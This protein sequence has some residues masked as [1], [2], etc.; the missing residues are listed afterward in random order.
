MWGPCLCQC[1]LSDCLHQSVALTQAGPYRRQTNNSV[2]SHVCV[3]TGYLLEVRGQFNKLQ[4]EIE[5]NRTEIMTYKQHLFFQHN[6]HTNLNT[7]PTVSHGG[8]PPLCS[9]GVFDALVVFDTCPPIRE[10]LHPIMDCL[11]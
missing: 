9:D 3:I 11:T 2:T 7:C 4:I 10:L 8:D 1:N 6:L 5:K